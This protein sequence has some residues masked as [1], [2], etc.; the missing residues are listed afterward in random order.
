MTPALTAL[1]GD[2]LA[3]KLDHFL[4]VFDRADG[5][6]AQ[7]PGIAEPLDHLRIGPAPKADSPD[8]V[9]VG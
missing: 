2:H 8:P 7:N 4:G 1:N 6:D 5:R 3:A 9:A